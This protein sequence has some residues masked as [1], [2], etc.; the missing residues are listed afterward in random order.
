MLSHISNY[1]QCQLQH[2][3]HLF[4]GQWV[5]ISYYHHYRLNI[6]WVLDK[7]MEDG[8]LVFPMALIYSVYLIRNTRN[9]HKK[10]RVG[11][12]VSLFW[13]IT[14]IDV[15]ILISYHGCILR[16]SNELF[17]RDTE[18]YQN[19]ILPSASYQ[20]RK[21]AGCAC[22]GNAGNV[23]LAT[24]GLRSRHVSRHVRDARAVMHAGI[25]K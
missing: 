17:L 25:A 22:T 20:I 10:Q 13:N 8:R 21:I 12:Y 14:S 18:L 9:E 19:L 1:F 4:R 5:C 2:I 7:D 6:Q 15:D 16:L 23:F 3:W 24:A 11:G